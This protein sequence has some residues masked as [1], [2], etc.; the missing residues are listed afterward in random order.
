MFLCSHSAPFLVLQLLH[1]LMKNESVSVICQRHKSWSSPET[2]KQSDVWKSSWTTSNKNI[3][4]QHTFLSIIRR[5]FSF[6]LLTSLW[7]LQWSSNR[8]KRIKLLR[9]KYQLPHLQ[10]SSRFFFYRSNL[11]PQTENPHSPVDISHLRAF[12]YQS[13]TQDDGCLI[14]RS[15]CM[16]GLPDGSICVAHWDEDDASYSLHVSPI[17]VF[18]L[19]WTPHFVIFDFGNILI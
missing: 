11:K 3:T 9:M 14:W 7:F 5:S 10:H 2:F 19:L 4:S 12:F 15:L 18:Q 8:M 13:W 17:F 16:N 1:L 6:W